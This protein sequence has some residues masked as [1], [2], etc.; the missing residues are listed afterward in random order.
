MYQADI[1]SIVITGAQAL[2]L[3]PKTAI[4]KIMAELRVLLP[5]LE[6]PIDTR[7]ICEKKAVFSCEVETQT[8][9]PLN[10][11]P[12]SNLFLAGD[13]TQNPYAATL[14]SAVYS[15]KKAAELLSLEDA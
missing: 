8:H 7:W 4:P 14:E 10:N 15:G 11:T 3:N 6:D 12:I 1:L 5:H 13:Y 2:M 9:R